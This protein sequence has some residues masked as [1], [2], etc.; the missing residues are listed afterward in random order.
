MTKLFSPVELL[1]LIV[2]AVMMSAFLWG[3][4]GT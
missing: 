3:V 4:T 1:A 2:L